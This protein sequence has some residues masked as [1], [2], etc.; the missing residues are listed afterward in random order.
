MAEEP[1]KPKP[2]GR[3][4]GSG[5]K[6]KVGPSAPSPA[7]TAGMTSLGWGALDS[8]GV[9]DA[10]RSLRK[11]AVAASAAI[12]SS[13]SSSFESGKAKLASATPTSP[14]GR[15]APATS[16]YDPAMAV[17]EASGE[18]SLSGGGDG[19][20]VAGRRQAGDGDR[21]DDMGVSHTPK[22]HQNGEKG[23]QVSSSR[24]AAPAAT[25][26]KHDGGGS[27]DG[28]AEI[29]NDANKCVKRDR[30]SHSSSDPTSSSVRAEE[31]DDAGKDEEKE[32]PDPGYEGPVTPKKRGRGRPPSKARSAVATPRGAESRRA[33]E[34]EGIGEGT[35]GRNDDERGGALC[36]GGSGG[37]GRSRDGDEGSTR[38]VQAKKSH[39]K[40][41]STGS[42]AQQRSGSRLQPRR[43]SKEEAAGR[44]LSMS[45]SP[46][47]SSSDNSARAFGAYPKR[48]R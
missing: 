8:D 32:H 6:L 45:S 46:R 19:G 42:F 1:P 7:F 35:R 12:S 4:K 10:A 24:E 41:R 14:P 48:R 28:A 27:G 9:V 16:S 23:V 5:K 15:G 30:P 2:R 44:G 11:A 13:S 26:G 43:G 3:P 25:M 17:K 33:G 40:K 38:Y 47:G 37:G 34:A 18:D 22:F 39:R 29:G 36:G 20:S 21:C 31:D